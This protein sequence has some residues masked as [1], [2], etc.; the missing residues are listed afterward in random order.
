[1]EDPD[2]YPALKKVLRENPIPEVRAA[3]AVALARLGIRDALDLLLESLS[4]DNRYFRMSAV[5]AVSQ[6]RDDRA[7]KP[8][9]DL[10]RSDRV[11]DEERAIVLVA[12]GNT[13]DPSEVPAMK[14][15]ASRYNFLTER[16]G[17]LLQIVR[18]L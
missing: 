12:L 13:A 1:G 16:F 3:A 9:M 14:R 2:A 4:A 10:Y 17:V 11:N 18:L 5:L 7:L 6:F 8:L 15:I